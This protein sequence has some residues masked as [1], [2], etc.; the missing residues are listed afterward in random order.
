MQRLCCFIL[1]WCVGWVGE[2]ITALWEG[3]AR[4]AGL[5]LEQ[6]N[7]GFLCQRHGSHTQTTFCRSEDQS[8]CTVMQLL[9]DTEPLF[10][11]TDQFSVDGSPCVACAVPSLMNPV[12]KP[13]TTTSFNAAVPDIPRKR[14]GSDSDNQ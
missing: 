11:L 3:G 13:A 5:G 7:L 12:T 10:S 4:F 2:I 14:K 1:P 9:L 8:G 6:C